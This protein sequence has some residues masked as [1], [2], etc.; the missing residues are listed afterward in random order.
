MTLRNFCLLRLWYTKI[1]ANHFGIATYIIALWSL[2][3]FYTHTR[4][5]THIYIKKYIYNH[6][7]KN[8]Y[9]YF[10]VIIKKYNSRLLLMSYCLIFF[11]VALKYTYTNSIIKYIY[12]Q[13][14]KKWWLLRTS[15]TKSIEFRTNQYIY[16][17]VKN[18][19]AL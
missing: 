9:T 16:T 6:S 3:W 10:I 18:L 1:K 2:L 19:S 11:W 8:L 17:Y 4:A 14:Y 15:I 7:K 5:H 12:K 13:H